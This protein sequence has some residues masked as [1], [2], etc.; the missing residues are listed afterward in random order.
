MYSRGPIFRSS[1][2]CLFYLIINQVGYSGDKC[3]DT[4]YNYRLSFGPLWISVGVRVRLP[5][6]L[7][8]WERRC[9]IFR[10]WTLPHNLWYSFG[11]GTQFLEKSGC[12]EQSLIS[13]NLQVPRKHNRGPG[14]GCWVIDVCVCVCVCVCLSVCLSS[15]ME[16][17]ENLYRHTLPCSKII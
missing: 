12:I 4:K 13:T 7:W 1:R 9:A 17:L 16:S 14:S 8:W 10:N 2:E 11:N 5:Y 3:I 15:G 6:R